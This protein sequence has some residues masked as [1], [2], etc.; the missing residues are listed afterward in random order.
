MSNNSGHNLLITGISSDI[1]MQ[2]INSYGCKY[3]CILGQYVHMNDKLE[4]LKDEFGEKLVLIEADLS[5]ES[6][7]NIM[8]D[9]LIAS[10]NKYDTIVHLASPKA[11]NVQFRKETWSSIDEH[12][13]VSVRSIY[14]LLKV[15]LPDMAKKKYGRVVIMLTAYTIGT[16]PKFQSTYVTAKYALLGLM[17]SLAAEYRPYGVCINGISPGMIDTKF[18][19][20][21]PHP[22][23]EQNIKNS[24]LGRN[25]TPEDIIPVIRYLLSEEA[26]M[27]SGHNLEILN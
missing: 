12:I 14:E 20:E 11:D 21:L 2:L 10:Q 18:I 13:T 22:V 23:V 3:D 1:G 8:T 24:V 27:I 16:P 15:T 19:E 25:L 26:R 5:T 4:R 6:G 9:S 17:K 7:I